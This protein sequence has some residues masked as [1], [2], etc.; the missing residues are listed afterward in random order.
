MKMLRPRILPL[1]FLCLAQT[2]LHADIHEPRM[3]TFK[4]GDQLELS[5]ANA[6][7]TT[8][9][10]YN[11]KSFG[12]AD[13]YQLSEKDQAEIILWSRQ[14][15]QDLLSGRLEPT[16]FTQR[17]RKDAKRLVDGKLV[18][19]DWSD[20]REPDF[21]AI[22]TS[23]S[24][25]GP[26]RRF[27]PE[28]VRFYKFY[29]EAYGD[30]MELV[31]CSWDRSKRDMIKYMEDEGM[32]WYGNWRTRESSFW[33]DYQG[34]GIPCLVI[35]DRN[36]N[37]L[38]HSYDGDDYYGP[39]RPMEKLRELLLFASNDP[40]QR[41]SVTTPGIDTAKLSEAIRKRENEVS[42]Q[43]KATPPQP[44]STPSTLLLDLQ[45]PAAEETTLNVRVAID[46]RGMVRE[47][48]LVTPGSKTLQEIVRKTVILW[49]FMPRV[50]VEEGAVASEFIMP[51]SLNIAEKHLQ[52]IGATAS[53]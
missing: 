48:S 37:L 41:I 23:A 42:R 14:R 25:C 32:T 53:N 31:L 36:G 52:P 9:Y 18:D 47:A 5:F 35:V 8:V 51:I 22:Y 33:R 39:K 19:P 11:D 3:W 40:E 30:R 24:W 45:D 12:S 20:A 16:E 28:L 7:G 4:N 43:E 38:A 26:C 27:T 17:F 50:T 15:D 21:Y 13:L 44:I 6:Y 10:F 1:L 46:K 34:N 49:Q 29:K 2:G